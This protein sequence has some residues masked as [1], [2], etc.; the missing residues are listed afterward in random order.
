MLFDTGAAHSFISAMCAEILGLKSVVADKPLKVKSPLGKEVVI[1]SVC[2]SCIIRL[3]GKNLIFD[4]LVIRMTGFDV[5]LGMDWLSKHRIVSDFYK[6]MV[7]GHFRMDQFLEKL[8]PYQGL[9]VRN[10]SLGGHPNSM[11]V[12]IGWEGVGGVDLVIPRVVC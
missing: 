12:G 2:K 3:G 8:K 4:L 1:N 10:S 9:S 6:R 11:V 7:L 5:T